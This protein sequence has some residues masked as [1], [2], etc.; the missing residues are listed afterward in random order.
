MRRGYQPFKRR[1]G[2]RRPA[3]VTAALLTCV[4]ET[5]GFFRDQLDVIELSLAS[6]VETAGHLAD[7]MVVDNGSCAPVRDVLLERWRQGAIDHLL[8]NRRNVGKANASRQIL[9]AAPGDLV[10][11]ADG[12]LYFRSGWLEAALEIVESYPR[13]GM[14]GCVPVR[15]LT[16]FCTESTLRWAE[17]TAEVAV[18]RGDLIA[19]ADR[20]EYYR[21]LGRSESDYRED[22]DP[23][24]VLL[25]YEG[26]AA[27]VGASHM[28][29]LMPRDAVAL[30][31]ESRF[32]DAI[33]GDG[34]YGLDLAIDAAGRLRLSTTRP[35]VYHI[36]NRIAEPWL[37]EEFRRLT[38]KAARP[39]RRIGRLWRRWRP[40]KLVQWIHDWSFERLYTDEEDAN[41]GRPRSR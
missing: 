11:Y 21:S 2:L 13:V 6:L 23:E 12:D 35:L 25:E 39:P 10:A 34:E 28:Q 40:R 7:V 22:G 30:A 14:V 33:G 15:H 5:V 41:E 29:Y 37:R 4:P 3:R 8:L 36:G 18:R 9:R 32:R 20:E 16:R 38:G 24:D 1:P 17:E 26:V 31:R 19:E 27:F